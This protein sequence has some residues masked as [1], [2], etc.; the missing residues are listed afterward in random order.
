MICNIQ[1]TEIYNS[2]IF[3][4]RLPILDAESSRTLEE[5]LNFIRSVILSIYGVDLAD[6]Q[7]KWYKVPFYTLKY[8]YDNIENLNYHVNEEFSVEHYTNSE[9]PSFR[10]QHKSI[11]A[12]GTL[13]VY[14]SSLLKNGLVVEIIDPSL[15]ALWVK[16]KAKIDESL[17]ALTATLDNLNVN[18]TINALDAVSTLGDTTIASLTVA[19]SALFRGPL[20]ALDTVTL[21]ASLTANGLSTFNNNVDIYGE[22]YI[23]NNLF[24]YGD[25]FLDKNLNISG[26]EL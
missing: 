26:V 9:N 6:P 2:A 12:R 24:V 13:T 4:D 5:D 22:I 18:M 1:Q 15:Y 25:V 17:D 3:N 20:N 8:L 21:Q 11:T 10:G 16:G 14:D 19:G 7:N 23:N